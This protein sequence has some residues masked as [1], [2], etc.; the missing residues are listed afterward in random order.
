MDRIDAEIIEWISKSLVVKGDVAGHPF[1]GNQY[2]AVV[3]EHTYSVPRDHTPSEAHDI[4][5][6]SHMAKGF[7]ARTAGNEPLA[8]LHFDAAVKHIDA[9]MAK[10]RPYAN[11]IN[12]AEKSAAD[13]AERKAWKATDNADAASVQKASE[14]VKGGAGS[15]AQLGHAFNGNQYTTGSGGSGGEKREQAAAGGS[16]P[17]NEFSGNQYPKPNWGD[18][19]LTPKSLKDVEVHKGETKTAA[20]IMEAVSR[21]A[22]AHPDTINGY[23]DK[24]SHI[25]FLAE[26]E[27]AIPKWLVDKVTQKDMD[28]LE[29]N[30]YHAANNVIASQRPDLNGWT[31]EKALAQ[32]DTQK[33]AEIIQKGDLA[34][35]AFRGNQYTSAQSL[36]DR[37]SNL[38]YKVQEGV[39]PSDAGR[40]NPDPVGS[41]HND[42]AD[43][44]R[45]IAAQHEALLGSLRQEAQKASAEGKPILYNHIM[46][47]MGAHADA[48]R[49][50]NEAADAH[51]QV[52]N[53]I[54]NPRAGNWSLQEHEAHYL[55]KLADLASAQAAQAE[56][57]TNI[58]PATE[59]SNTVS[60]PNADGQPT[61]VAH[62]E[63]HSIFDKSAEIAKG[64]LPG[65]EFHGNQWTDSRGWNSHISTHTQNLVDKAKELSEGR[66]DIHT[67]Y[68]RGHDHR[69]VSAKHQEIADKFAAR[70]SEARKHGDPFSASR[71]QEVASAHQAAADA[72][73]IAAIRADEAGVGAETPDEGIATKV[74]TAAPWASELSTAAAQAEAN[75][76]GSVGPRADSQNLIDQT[77]YYHPENDFYGR[78]PQDLAD[79][80]ARIEASNREYAAR[81]QK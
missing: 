56:F 26:H 32:W 14:I 37:A 36:S 76:N 19:N 53:L 45:G 23:S 38:H 75:L 7:A 46:S 74:F 17:P 39:D 28:V 5:C 57:R 20:Q 58:L 6:D 42:V 16:P 79:R 35:H 10:D 60:M 41:F 44:H 24:E 47:E 15:G 33:S 66:H 22:D 59:G 27:D 78:S 49:A 50:H 31:K 69:D 9:A 63:H 61:V 70:A 2:S 8:Q 21:Y 12:S 64:D 52:I 13:N 71:F 77:G 48:A 34:G 1:H 55:T 73:S 80:D 43:E 72:H 11:T 18:K 54:N 62:V 68:D 29:D 30:N 4:M 51:N 67:G 81:N 25:K 3:G 65:H 40:W